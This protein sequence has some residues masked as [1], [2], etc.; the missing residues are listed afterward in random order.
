MNIEPVLSHKLLYTQSPSHFIRV[1]K[2][3]QAMYVCRNTEA[4][5]GSNNH[6]F[7]VVQGKNTQ[8]IQNKDVKSLRGHNVE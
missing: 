6:S 8:S 4:H 1:V 3:R 5:F 7:D 2:T